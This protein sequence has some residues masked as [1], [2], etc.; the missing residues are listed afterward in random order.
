MMFTKFIHEQHKTINISYY[1][2]TNSNGKINVNFILR[3]PCDLISRHK[4]CSE[5]KLKS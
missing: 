1:S 2:I 4:I 3:G 5:P